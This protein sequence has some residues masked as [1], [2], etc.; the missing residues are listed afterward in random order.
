[1]REIK[2]LG[3]IK[4]GNDKRNYKYSIFKCPN[5]SKEVLRKSKDGIKQTFC[6]H[7]CYAE[8]R[9]PRGSYKEKV[10][11]SGYLYIYKPT[12]PNSIKS[13]YVA[14]HRL[15]AEEK[16]GRFLKNNEVVHHINE[17]KHD[18]SPDNL[19]VMTA[20]EHNKLHAIKRKRC[21]DGKYKI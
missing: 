2:C 6:S 20:S 21:D 3:N 7:Q 18:N 5:C 19:Q 11:I 10:E 16:I 8:N 1:M 12:H 14:E 13:G 17:N 15:V 9:K 4:T